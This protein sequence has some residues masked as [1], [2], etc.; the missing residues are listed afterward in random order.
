MFSRGCHGL[1]FPREKGAKIGRSDKLQ[2]E[3]GE[4]RLK[5]STFQ[6]LG[7]A[8]GWND[9]ERGALSFPSLHGS[10]P[11]PIERPCLPRCF[12]RGSD[13][14]DVLATRSKLKFQLHSLI[15]AESENN[16]EAVVATTTDRLTNLLKPA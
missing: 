15:L 9:D 5:Q 7:L 6:S 12:R 16:D 13:E 11:E 10:L 2:S 1:T 4:A 8:A 14:Q 3:R